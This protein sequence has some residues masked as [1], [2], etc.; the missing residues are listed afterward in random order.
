[1]AITKHDIF[2]NSDGRCYYCGVLVGENWHAEHL[3]PKSQGGKYNKEN[4]VVSC[5]ICNLRKHCNTVEEFRLILKMRVLRELRRNLEVYK[6]L[7]L[8]YIKKTDQEEIEII[9]DS[10]SEKIAKTKIV[11]WGEKN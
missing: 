5:Q 2:E 8:P 4:I 9:F 1:M 7:I 11:F 6:K 10:L 3:Q